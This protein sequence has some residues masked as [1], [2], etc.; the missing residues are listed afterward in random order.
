MKGGGIQ[1]GRE[2]WRS[3]GRVME[4][5]MDAEMDEK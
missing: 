5:G 2:G 1:R 3:D 4:G